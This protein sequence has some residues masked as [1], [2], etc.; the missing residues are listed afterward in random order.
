MFLKCGYSKKLYV[1]FTLMRIVKQK[2]EVVRHTFNTNLCLQRV[3]LFIKIKN[4]FLTPRHQ[5]MTKRFSKP[6]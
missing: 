5:E 2:N 3:D 1:Q 4:N 6:F